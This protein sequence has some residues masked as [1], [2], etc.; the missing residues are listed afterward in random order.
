VLR[1]RRDAHVKVK[2]VLVVVKGRVSRLSACVSDDLST[3][4]I[5]VFRPIR[6]AFTTLA[7]YGG[8]LLQLVVD[9]I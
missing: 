9:S 7:G 2:G 8:K 6:S 3:V 1:S 4:E 5:I